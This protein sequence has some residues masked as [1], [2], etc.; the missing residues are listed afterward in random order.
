MAGGSDHSYPMKERG[1]FI[2][3]SLVNVLKSSQCGPQTSTIHI[4]GDLVRN[5]DPQPYSDLQNQSVH[6]NQIPRGSAC[7]FK[8]G[9]QH[10]LASLSLKR[11]EFKPLEW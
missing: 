3:F 1:R 8:F 6:F 5:E 7:T 4:P 11:D 2:S 10:S 9:K